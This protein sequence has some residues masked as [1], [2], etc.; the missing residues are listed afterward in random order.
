M[1]KC[2]LQASTNSIV[3]SRRW[4]GTEAGIYIYI[5]IMLS[6]ERQTTQHRDHYPTLYDRCVSSFKVER[7]G[8]RFNVLIRED[9]KVQPFFRF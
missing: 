6:V 7:M 9:A 3:E 8:L 4:S 2:A 1:F 5:L